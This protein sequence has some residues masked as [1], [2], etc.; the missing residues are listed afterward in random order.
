VS[1]NLVDEIITLKTVSRLS[2]AEIA[3]RCGVQIADV[4]DVLIEAGILTLT[5]AAKELREESL[6]PLRSAP[7]PTRP[8]PPSDERPAAADYNPDL[9]HCLRVVRALGGRGFPFLSFDT[10]AGATGA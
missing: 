10:G 8:A 4:A 2:P 5:P 1:P 7:R 9:A 6:R 3:R